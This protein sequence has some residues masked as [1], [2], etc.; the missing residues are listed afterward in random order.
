[1]QICKGCNNIKISGVEVQCNVLFLSVFDVVLSVKNRRKR[2]FRIWE[3]AYV[4]LQLLVQNQTR[5]WH[6]LLNFH[7]LRKL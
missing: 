7:T 1:M 4:P 3:N 2:V 6:F 5:K